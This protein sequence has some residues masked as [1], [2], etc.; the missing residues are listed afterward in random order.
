M[1]LVGEV[2]VFGRLLNVGE[3]KNIHSEKVTGLTI[4]DRG[5]A[6]WKKALDRRVM[7]KDLEDRLNGEDEASIAAKRA[8]R[9]AEVY[10]ACYCIS[11]TQIIIF[12]IVGR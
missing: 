6:S 3:N 4:N 7:Y 2:L 8:Q 5:S 1:E 12:I 11:K 10:L 9:T